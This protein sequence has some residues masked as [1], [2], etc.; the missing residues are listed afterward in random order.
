MN[1][2]FIKNKHYVPIYINNQIEYEILKFMS[3]SV[4]ELS[5]VLSNTAFAERLIGKF[6]IIHYSRDKC[7]VRRNHWNW[8]L[9]TLTVIRKKGWKGRSRKRGWYNQSRV[10]PAPNG[11]VL[12]WDW[13]VRW[14]HTLIIIL[15]RS[16]IG[17]HFVLKKNFVLLIN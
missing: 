8:V 2:T 15:R 1:I 11:C 4:E 16:G 10:V 3:R 17:R 13:R 14:L 12:K 7:S 9:F 6:P 5:F